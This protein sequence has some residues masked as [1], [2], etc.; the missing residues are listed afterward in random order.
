MKSHKSEENLIQNNALNNYW[1]MLRSQITKKGLNTCLWPGWSIFLYWPEKCFYPDLEGNCTRACI[2]TLLEIFFWVGQRHISKFGWK[3]VS[4][5]ARDMSSQRQVFRL[6]SYA[7]VRANLSLPLVSLNFW[8]SCV[9][10]V[11]VYSQWICNFSLISA[12]W[13]YRYDMQL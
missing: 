4:N 12:S 5:Q 3:H 8:K 9:K 13:R 6:P 7:T 2:L 1:V 11:Q 10:C